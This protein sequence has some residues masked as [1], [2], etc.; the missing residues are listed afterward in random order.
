[1]IYT[2]RTPQVWL[3]LISHA[4]LMA[5]ELDSTAVEGRSNLFCS[6][7]SCASLLLCFHYLLSPLQNPSCL[8]GPERTLLSPGR[9]SRITPGCCAP[10]SICIIIWV[11]NQV[12]TSEHLSSYCLQQLFF[13]FPSLF[14]VSYL[15][16]RSQVGLQDPRK[17]GNSINVPC[18]LVPYLPHST[19]I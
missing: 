14:T 11:S 15:R 6:V 4:Q 12:K 3:S 10:I 5:T 13:I 1:M 18:L 8:L 2:Y 19:H 17:R 9:S 7:V 16:N